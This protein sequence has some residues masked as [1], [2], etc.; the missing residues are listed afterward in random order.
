MTLS[1]E[2]RG[3]RGFGATARACANELHAQRWTVGL[4]VSASMIR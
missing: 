2:I 3:R 1:H 4:A